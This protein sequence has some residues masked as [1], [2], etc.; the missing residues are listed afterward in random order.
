MLSDIEADVVVVGSGIGGSLV[1][2][3][4]ASRGKTVVLLEQ[5]PHLTTDTVATIFERHTFQV[6]PPVPV[7]SVTRMSRQKKIAERH[8]PLVVG[9]LANFYMAVSLRMRER[10]YYNWPLTYLEIEPYYSEAEQL[11]DVGGQTGADP[12]EPPRSRAYPSNL[13]EMS[14]TAKR[15]QRGA[16]AIDINGFPHP[17]AIRFNKGCRRCFYCN[18]ISCP[19]GVK[20][21]PTRLLRENTHLP[22]R[23]FPQHTAQRIYVS[24]R[25]MFKVVEHIE[26]WNQKDKQTVRCRGKVYILCG[27]ALQTPLL[28]I[29]SGLQEHNP[30]IGTHLMTHCMATVWGIFPDTIS[31]NEEFDKW[32]TI[33]GFYFDEREEVRGLI[34]QEQLT[35]QNWILGHFPRPFHWLVRRY[36]PRACNLLVIAEDEPRVENRVEIDESAQ[37]IIRQRF[38]PKDIE[39][40]EFLVQ[41][42]KAILK[43]TGAW[44]TIR[45][46][47][48]SIFHACGTCRMGESEKTSVTDRYG[49]VWG[50]ENLFV[51]DA[52]LMPTSSGVNPSLTIAALALRI[53]D[54]V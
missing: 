44:T 1:A 23:L 46:N 27:G 40:R 3:K 26:V 37:I 4:V 15:V 30:L 51:A 16:Q 14:E 21:T 29:R 47:G 13:P 22:I 24:G 45:H 25:G 39:K 48:H 35:P 38:T 10:E 53:G 17:L 20:F 12:T 18:Q 36:F 34:Q 52:S 19:Y 5:G 2:Y 9:G 7:I 32:L 31:G 6:N 50:M 41:K 28:M 33:T 54:F 43:S 49:K 42:A 8:L 11:L